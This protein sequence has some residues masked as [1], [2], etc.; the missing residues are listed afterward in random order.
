M[1]RQLVIVALLAASLEPLL[2]KIGFGRGYSLL[3]LLF[4]RTIVAGLTAFL[5]T[6]KRLWLGWVQLGKVAPL[7]LLLFIVNCATLFALQY[8]NV[9]SIVIIAATIPLFVALTNQWLGRDSLQKTFWFGFATSFSGVCL[10]MGLLD[11]QPMFTLISSLALIITVCCSTT[12]RVYMES[13]TQVIAP[14]QI[15][16]TIF[17]MNALMALVALPFFPEAL[18]WQAL[19]IATWTGIIAAIANITFISAIR[20]VG[21]TRMSIIDMLQRPLVMIAA[22]FILDEALSTWQIIGCLLTLLGTGLARVKKK[23]NSTTVS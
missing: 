8:I 6:K 17:T 16:F 13:V 11:K 14:S 5:F 4:F 20:L 15:T 10:S 18:E 9:S 23:L 21:S 22:V 12:Y 7:A 2:V 19:S 3:S 1:D